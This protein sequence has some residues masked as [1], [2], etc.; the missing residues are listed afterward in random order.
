VLT[1]LCSIK[2]VQVFTVLIAG[3]QVETW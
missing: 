2:S 1:N 3:T